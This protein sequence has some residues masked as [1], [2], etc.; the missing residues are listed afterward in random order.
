MLSIGCNKVLINLTI[1]PLFISCE[2]NEKFAHENNKF[3]SFSASQ[4]TLFFKEASFII[5]PQIPN[6][7]V[8]VCCNKLE[9]VNDLIYSDVGVWSVRR[10]SFSVRMEKNE[11]PLRESER[12][13]SILISFSSSVV[14]RRFI[15]Y[16]HIF[17]HIVVF[18]VSSAIKSLLRFSALEV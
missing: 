9:S 18:I 6:I 4:D 17:Y 10:A 14:H 3:M 11:H 8:C 16:C 13:F 2:T 5:S 7:S 1:N 12:R 15:I